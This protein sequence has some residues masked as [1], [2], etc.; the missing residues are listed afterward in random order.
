MFF[1][2]VSITWSWNSLF[3]PCVVS[4]LLLSPSSEFSFYCIFSYRISFGSSVWFLFIYSQSLSLSFLCYCCCLVTMSCPTLQPMDCSTPGF[5][6]LDYLSEFAQ[7]HVCCIDDAIQLSHPLLPPSPPAL[8]FSQ[9]QG[10]FQWVGSFLH[11]FMFYFQSLNM[12][13]VTTRFFTVLVC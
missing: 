4:N 11:I 10:L 13:I 7:T 3:F 8:N 5:P 6:I 9:H 2:V 1:C 12:N